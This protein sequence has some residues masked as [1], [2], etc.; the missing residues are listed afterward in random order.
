MANE[1]SPNPLSLEQ[2]PNGYLKMSK[3]S[4]WDMLARQASSD[5]L[6]KLSLPL[7][8][9]LQ[10]LSESL[11]VILSTS[12]LDT[13]TAILNQLCAEVFGH[14]PELEAAAQ[15]ANS[16][17]TGKAQVSGTTH[18]ASSGEIEPEI[19]EWARQQLN[20]EETVEGLREIRET[21]GLELVDFIHEVEKE[22]APHE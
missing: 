19:L 20:E 8:Q 11:A 21:G 18:E 1:T 2:Q 14:L 6:E 15:E 13:S 3:V 10:Q 5:E 16:N 12:D 7:Q 9:T 4:F 17:H 22:A